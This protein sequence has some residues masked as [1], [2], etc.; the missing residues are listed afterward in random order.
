M[1]T[2]ELIAET[3]A[4]A[5][6]LAALVVPS[7]RARW[8]AKKTL[9]EAVD[10]QERREGAHTLPYRTDQRISAV[11]QRLSRTIGSRA[12]NKHIR[13]RIEQELRK[14]GMVGQVTS[15]RG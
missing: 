15:P 6:A 9:K 7:L 8:L 12:F 11:Q 3:V 4:G 10:E 1:T 5:G 14:R 2:V 13:K